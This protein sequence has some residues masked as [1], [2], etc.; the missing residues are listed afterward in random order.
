MRIVAAL[1][2]NA[3][4]RRG[5]AI[6]AQNQRA[7]AARA[8]DALAPLIT[9]HEVVITHG[10]GPQV[11]LLLDETE[12]DTS[13][14]AYPL[15]VVGAE[16]EGMIGYLVEEA[17]TRRLPGTAFATLL[18]LTVVDADDPALRRPTKPIGPVLDEATAHRL[19][20]ERGFTVARDTGGW[21]RVVPSPVPLRPLELRAIAHLVDGGFT[22]VTSGGGGVPVT[23]DAAGRPTGVEGVVDKDLAAAVLARELGASVLLLLTDVDGLYRNFGSPAAELIDRLDLG[24]AAAMLSGGG[25]PAGSMRPKLE[26]AV[27]FATAGGTSIIA[28]L[29]DAVRALL[30]QAGTTVA[31]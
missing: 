22:V 15:D 5:E 14:P 6:S 19:A 18:T 11:G 2:G 25:L 1:G 24:D 23:L 7:N 20:S 8:A 29:D 9:E 31:R 27:A 28:S 26:A 4:A 12:H 21:R 13:V 16:T 30:G 10:N 17:L 3:L